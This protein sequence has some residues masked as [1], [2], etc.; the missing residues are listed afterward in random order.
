MS[1]LFVLSGVLQPILAEVLTYNGAFNK[2]TLLLV[3]PNCIGMSFTILTN[4]NGLKTIKYVKWKEITI[5]AI[6]DVVSQALCMVGLVYA[7]SSIYIVIYSSTTV[8]AAMWSKIILSKSLSSHQW[9]GVC[10]MVFGLGVTALK[11][12]EVPS[13][14]A[15]MSVHHDDLIGICCILI[16]ASV[17]ALTWILIEKYTQS[18]ITSDH[19]D[20]NRDIDIENESGKYGEMEDLEHT[21]KV[22]TPAPELI[23]SIMGWYGCAIYGF[24]QVVYTLPHYNELLLEPIQQKNGNFVEIELAFAMLIFV[25][26]IHAI[27]F[28]SLLQRIGAVSTGVMKGIQTISVFVISHFAFCKYQE[29]QCFTRLRGASLILVIIGIFCYINASRKGTTVQNGATRNSVAKI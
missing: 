2:S 6:Y 26:F 19:I 20:M 12:L 16:G 29:S 21:G 4:M 28:Y 14:P 23:C 3:L 13:T 7:G 17:H 22:K 27:A 9:I 18:Y 1:F 25:C 8:F 15:E 10:I 11:D 24:W 5:L